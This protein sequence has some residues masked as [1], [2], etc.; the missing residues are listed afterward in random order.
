M[1]MRIVVDFAKDETGVTSPYPR[2]VMVTKL[3]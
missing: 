3:K 2:V 1:A